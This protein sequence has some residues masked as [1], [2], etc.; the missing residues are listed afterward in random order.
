IL[1]NNNTMKNGLY[2]LPYFDTYLLV[3]GIGK[4]NAASRLA[5]VLATQPVDTIYNI[6]FAGATTPFQIADVVLIE[7]ACYH[8][9]DLTLF[10]QQKGQVPGCPPRFSSDLNLIKDVKAKIKNLKTGQL[11]TGDKFMTEVIETSFLADMEGTS[12]F[13][14]AFQH[15]KPIISIKIVSDIIGSNDHINTYKAFESSIGSSLLKQ[16]L[17]HVFKGE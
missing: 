16:V 15:Q 12:L 1:I 9:F 8:D 13:Q 17:D 11:Y 3:T 4:V 6:G 10:G 5:Y 7:E 14:V 2:P